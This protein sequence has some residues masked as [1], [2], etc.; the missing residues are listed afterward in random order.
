MIFIL[1]FA[2]ELGAKASSLTE[3]DLLSQVVKIKTYAYNA[4]TQSYITKQYGSA[5]VIAKNRII[6]NAHVILEGEND[7]PTQLYEICTSKN[8]E[9][10][11]NC[12]MT[13]RL[14]AYDPI[15]DLALLE[16]SS[17]FSITPVQFTKST[18]SLVIGQTVIIY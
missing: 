15:A 17:N 3:K 8:Y 16:P 10:P 5:V 13:A 2:S 18:S 1:I 6:T 11:P 7:S 12:T 9:S 14:I 4:Q